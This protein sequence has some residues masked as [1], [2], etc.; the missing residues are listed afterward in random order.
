M[1]NILNSSLNFVR[2]LTKSKEFMTLNKTGLYAS[3]LAFITIVVMGIALRYFGPFGRN[4]IYEFKPTL[5]NTESFLSLNKTGDKLELGGLLLKNKV[6]RFSLDNQ[7]YLKDIKVALNYKPGQKEIKIGVRANETDPFIYK[8]LFF[9]PI[10]SLSWAKIQSNGMT[11][12]QKTKQFDSIPAF[13]SQLT[14]D[15]K[16]GLYQI[17][18][19]DLIPFIYPNLKQTNTVITAPIRGNATMYVLVSKGDLNIKVSKQDLNMTDGADS[20]SLSLSL[21]NIKV[22]EA[23]IPDDGFADRSKSK[24]AAQTTSLSVPKAKPGVYKLDIKF[25]SAGNDGLIS[26]I[27]VN[28]AKVVFGGSVLIWNG[29]PT[30]FYTFDPKIVT[31]TSWAD[32][33]QNLKVD[34][35]ADLAIKDIKNK[36]NFDLAKTMK[37]KPA[38]E[39]YKVFSPK[40]NINFG[41]GSYFSF[42]PDTYFD[43][44]IIKAQVLNT[45]SVQA[46]IEKNLDFI[47]TTLNP[48][49]EQDYWLMSELNFNPADFQLK[50]DKIFFSLEVPDLDKQGGSLEL[51]GLTVTLIS[52]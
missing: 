44:K 25:D 7:K 40:G 23:N 48:N 20:L 33:I 11:L 26:K 16:V 19:N 8:S 31:S 10:N 52:K 3:I 17:N 35:K 49:K 36:F 18:V 38:E 42:N 32:A 22:T 12:F 5:P 34:D 14:P 28:Q 41:T 27:E 51:G 6:T 37:G 9:D 1:K 21:N 47:L 24:T 45:N 29:A 46:D 15:K 30:A 4:S 13:L 50:G 2:N 39:I 43:P